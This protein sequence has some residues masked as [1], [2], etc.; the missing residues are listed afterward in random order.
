MVEREPELG[1]H[2][3]ADLL[4]LLEG[5]EFDSLMADVRAH[6]LREPIVLLMARSSTDAIATARAVPPGLNHA[7]NNGRPAMTATRRSRSC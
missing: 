4:P 3:A 6:G 7:S 1:S 2:P 5:P